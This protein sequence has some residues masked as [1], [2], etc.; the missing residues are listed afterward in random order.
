MEA[1]RN[2]LHS[3]KSSKRLFSWSSI[4]L[5]VIDTHNKKNLNKVKIAKHYKIFNYYFNN[6]NIDQL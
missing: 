6:E 2:S 1:T 3:A 5:M 4:I